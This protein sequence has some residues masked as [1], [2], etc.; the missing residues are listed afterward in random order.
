M[1]LTLGA[2]AKQFIT[3][4]ELEGL[5]LVLVDITAHRFPDVRQKAAHKLLVIERNAMSQTLL[6]LTGI[7][8]KRKQLI[9]VAWPQLLNVSVMFCKILQS[10]ARSFLSL[11][12][13]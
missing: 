6:G 9:P 1:Y 12:C 8:N 7:K 5:L 3:L 13:F 11:S 10:L 4:A 2:R